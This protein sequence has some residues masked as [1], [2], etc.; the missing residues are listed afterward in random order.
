VEPAENGS[1]GDGRNGLTRL[2]AGLRPAAVAGGAGLVGSYLLPW[3]TVTGET[4]SR[5]APD[6]ISARELELVP[7]AVVVLGLL[8]AAVAL[9]RW[10]TP[11]RVAV[12]LFGLAGTGLGLFAW[13]FPDSDADIVRLGGHVGP[14]SAFGPGIGTVLTVLAG[15]AVVAAGFVGVLGSLAQ[16]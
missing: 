11:A 7:E 4:L 5:G 13:F 3:V 2:G 15:L 14:P 8:A 1:S 6:D 9:V 16:R 12:L 10:T